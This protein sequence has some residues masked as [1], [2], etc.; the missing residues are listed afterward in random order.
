MKNKKPPKPLSLFPPNPMPE[1]NFL[2]V[3]WTLHELDDELL[4]RDP[5]PFISTEKDSPPFDIKNLDLEFLLEDLETVKV[6]GNGRGGPVQL[7][8]HRWDGKLYALKV[9][10]MNLQEEEILKQFM[11]Y[12]KINKASKCSNV[13]SCNHSFYHRGDV[14]LVLEYMDRGSLIEVLRQVKTIPEPFLAVVC[15]QVLQGLVYL[16]HENHVIHGHIKPSNLLVNRNGEVKIADFGLSTLV[17]SSMD[18]KDTFVG[19]DNNYMSP[20]RI[21]GS[22]YDYSSD[23][24]SLGM[25]ALECAIGRY[26]YKQSEDPQTWPSIDELLKTNAPPNEFSSEFCSFVSASLQ[27][28]PEKR[29]S[30]LDLLSHPFIKKS[31]HLNLV[32]F[33][34]WLESPLN[35]PRRR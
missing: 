31:Q 24:W 12:L 18:Q 11:Q 2:T 15:D 20:E 28:S 8:R 19:T 30:S 10:K 23:I 17:A 29:A 22:T 35:Y 7:A 6:I 34:G 4:I 14:F 27:T 3:R 16:H 26:P 32:Y 13:V 9:I 5:A 33:V 21:S 1:P 25:V